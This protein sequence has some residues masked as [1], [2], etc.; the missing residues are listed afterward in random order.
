MRVDELEQALRDAL[1]EIG[2]NSYG[3]M[4]RLLDQHTYQ[5]EEPCACQQSGKRIS[6]REAQ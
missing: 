5:V 6:R 4:L 3:E 1:Q 2:Q